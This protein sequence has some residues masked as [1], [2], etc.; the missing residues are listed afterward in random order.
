MRVAVSRK[1]GAERAVAPLELFFDLVYSSPA[2]EARLLLA[3]QLDL[4]DLRAR[5]PGPGRVDHLDLRL[6]LALLREQALAGAA[7]R[8]GQA[9][10]AGRELCASRRHPPE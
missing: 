8:H 5:H 10:V 6:Q 9:D 4:D 2:T 3:L 1:P 7:E